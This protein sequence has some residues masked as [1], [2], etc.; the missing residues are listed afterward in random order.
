M[1]T[2]ET[3][4][5]KVTKESETKNEERKVLFEF[6]N[7]TLSGSMYNLYLDNSNE[8]KPKIPIYRNNK[9]VLGFGVYVKGNQIAK[10]I[11]DVNLQ[12]LKSE[13]KSNKSYDF[14]TYFVVSGKGIAV[15]HKQGE[16]ND[17]FSEFTQPVEADG[18]YYYFTEI[19]VTPIKD[20]ETKQDGLISLYR[21]IKER[22][23]LQNDL[24]IK[25]QMGL[26][27]TL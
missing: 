22:A 13:L 9:S 10:G 11:K 16:T 20:Y 19:I 26:L 7:A 21:S 5:T 3:K 1:E 18:Y 17:E 15:F 23:N 4:E 6:N 8:E 2:K 24:R 12:W 25:I 27:D 14:S